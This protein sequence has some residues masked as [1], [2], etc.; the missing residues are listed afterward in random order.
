VTSAALAARSLRWYRRSG[1]AVVLGVATA[2]AVLAGA[3]LIGDSVR[4]SLRELALRRLGRVDEVVRASHFFREEL[5]AGLATAAGAAAPMIVLEGAVTNEANGR[6]AFRVAVHGV[7]ARFWS[8]QGVADPLANLSAREAM[9]S[10]ALAAELGA[11][12]GASLLLRVQA[13]GDVPGSSLYGQRDQLGRTLRASLKGVLPRGALGE[14]ALASSQQDVR[15]VFV[16]L[17]LLQRT[18]RQERRANTIVLAN[19]QGEAMLRGRLRDAVKLD[20]LGL[21]LRLLETPRTLSLESRSALLEDAVAEAA[22]AVAAQQGL[23]AEPMLTYLANSL[24]V[25]AREVPY[26]LVTALPDASFSR[27][28]GGASA[29]ASEA[30]LLNDWAARELAAKPG[31]AL[32]MTYYLW[33]EGGRLVTDRAAFVVAGIVPLATGDRDMTPDYPG[34]SE[35]AHLSDWDP[36]FPVELGKIRPQDETYWERHRGTPK[37]FLPLARGRQLWRHRLGSLTS[38]RL[39]APGGAAAPASE[40]FERAL[41]GRLDPER[42]G[43]EL[44]PARRQALLAARGSTDFDQYFLYFSFFLIASA[45]LLAGLFFRLGVEQR[46]QEI[47]LLRA[48]GFTPGAVFRQLSLEGVALAALGAVPG[49]LL[50]PAF[51]AAVLDSLGRFGLDA[52]G[53]REL[54]LHV[55]PGALAAG[56][57]AGI[58]VA[59]FT[60]A[61]TLRGLVRREP[62]PLLL[63][64]RDDAPAREATRSRARLLAAAAL[65]A[66]LALAGAAWLGR[67]DPVGGFFGAGLSSLVALLAFASALL[68]RRGQ[69]RPA[70]GLAALGARSA[71]QR[72]G[73]SLLSIALVASATFVI[74]AVG[75]FRHGPGEG[76]EGRHS[77]TG[78]YALVGESL[79]PI[80]HDPATAAGRE[81]LNL[82]GLGTEPLRD[83]RITRLRLRP[84]D[85]ASCLNLY[86]PQSPRVL[87]A[88]SGFAREGRFAFSAS[89]AASPEAKA[90]PWLLLERDEG[91]GA[92]PAIADQNSIDYVL[93]SRLGGELELDTPGAGRVRLRLVAGLKASLFQSELI[94]AESQFQRLFPAEDGYRVFLIEAPRPTA[95]RVLGLLEERLSDSGLDLQPAA[96]RLLRY[97]RVENT[98]LAT[99]QVLGALGLLLGTIGLAAVMLRNAA[100]RRRELALLRAV[101]YRPGHLRALALSENALLLLS[102]LGIGSLCA[103]LAVAPAASLRGARPPLFELL[104]LLLV[105]LATGLL[106]S[107]L[108]LRAAVSGEVLEG[109]RTD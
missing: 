91:D 48:L 9:A 56:A 19:G 7:D 72:P 53:T 74:V 76:D 96:E 98:Y 1:V 41:L 62:R 106:V 69:E 42:R 108:A 89:L 55:A 18:L 83:A 88:P 64:A 12:S 107:R 87:G 40:A 36:P 6:R 22:A 90:N 61:L 4:A 38:V 13:P 44:V 60:I 33:E 57:L 21:R 59:G 67:L 3:L 63:G 5:A 23:S 47:G 85:D 27:P 17:R 37:A 39:I 35:S 28:L 94:V 100:E 109:L 95:E 81:P 26:S 51:A 75:A 24:R 14:F 25:G 58:A 101:G 43:F 49:A 97:Q 54:R 68:R 79:L 70:D 16:P 77:G 66:A 31:D 92:V 2:V 15:A 105:V 34:I 84:G 82:T 46:L 52:I 71:S 29:P 32:E 20:D 10:P 8:L 103:L 73:R 86:R 50:A 65:A 45:L 102:G 93:H 78:G 104:L 99:F 11:A 30:L 80:H